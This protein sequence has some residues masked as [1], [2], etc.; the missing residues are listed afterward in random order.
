MSVELLCAI[1]SHNYAKI[2]GIPRDFTFQ[3]KLCH[4]FESLIW[5]I[6]YAMMIRRKS[7]LAATNPIHHTAYKEYLD[8]YWGAHSHTK[9]LNSHMALMSAGMSP[10]RCIVDI[11]LFPDPLEAEFFRT[12]MR[13]LG[14]QRDGDAEPLTYEK[15]Q[16]L[17]RTY[18]RK[19]EQATRSTLAAT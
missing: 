9:L 17:F 11:V 6:I 15:V 10:R 19:T 14:P 13:L 8:G 4:D 1:E 16:T 2:C 5:V 18:I 7:T 3:H 12:A